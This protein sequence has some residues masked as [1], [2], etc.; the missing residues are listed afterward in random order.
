M[1][2][3][4]VI[5]ESNFDQYFFDT[6]KFGPQAG[7]IMAKFSAMAI[8]GDG[9][10][11]KDVVNLLK[12]DK[13][14]QAAMVMNKI[15]CARVPDCY[16]VCREICEDLISGMTEEEVGRKEYEFVIEAVFYTK[17][18][19]VPKDKNWEILTT[20]RFDPE[21]NTFKSNIEI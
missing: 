11:K 4:L 8:F 3:E 19:Y 12:T 1:T 14:P 20:L 6:R 10:E 17:K 13:A 18:E 5:D 2:E 16:K 15:H 21:T 9:P 7:Q